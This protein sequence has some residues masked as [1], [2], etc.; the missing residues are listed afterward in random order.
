MLFPSPFKTRVDLSI[1]IDRIWMSSPVWIV[2]CA[3][4]C[5]MFVRCSVKQ[6]VK[7]L[8]VLATLSPTH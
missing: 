1:D 6:Y 8:S 2:L 7:T 3:V 5:S 4:L